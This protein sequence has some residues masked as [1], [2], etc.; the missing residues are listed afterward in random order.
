[1]VVADSVENAR[2]AAEA[3]MGDYDELPNATG[4]HSALA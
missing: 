3:V 4:V 2:N 1:V